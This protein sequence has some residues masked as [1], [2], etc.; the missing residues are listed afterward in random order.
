[1]EWIKVMLSKG[2]IEKIYNVIYE[3]VCDLD[4][5]AS[6]SEG[7]TKQLLESEAEY[8]S[9]IMLKLEDLDKCEKV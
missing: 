7:Y 6:E 3:V 4:F 5:K 1:M 2:E 9:E 8:L